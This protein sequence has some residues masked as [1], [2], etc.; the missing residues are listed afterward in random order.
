MTLFGYQTILTR[1]DLEIVT[2]GAREFTLET[3]ELSEEDFND[4]CR[5]T[6]YKPTRFAIWPEYRG[7]TIKRKKKK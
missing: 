4:F 3:I 1:I 2:A 5:A 6:E 7:I